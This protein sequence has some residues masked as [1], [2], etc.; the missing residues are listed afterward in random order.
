MVTIETAPRADGAERKDEDESVD[1]CTHC[2]A[3][4]SY[5]LYDNDKVC[6]ECGHVPT[7]SEGP[8]NESDPWGEWWEHR[9]AEYSGFYGPNRIKFVGGFESAY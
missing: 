4:R 8:S 5:V 7:G 1:K 6:K 3:E 9:S 2:G